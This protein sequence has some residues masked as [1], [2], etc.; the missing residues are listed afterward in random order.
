[1]RPIWYLE[2]LFVTPPA[3]RR[4][5]G[6]ALMLHAEAFARAHGAERLTLSTAH[7]NHTAQAL[8]RKLRYVRDDYFWYFHHVLD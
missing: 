8:Y 4:G 1:M 3:R 7:D 2:D 5:I 6:E